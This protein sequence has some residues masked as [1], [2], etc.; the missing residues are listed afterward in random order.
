M[1]NLREYMR[2]K[3]AERR[4][5]CKL[6]GLCADCATDKARPNRTRCETCAAIN[7]RRPHY[8]RLNANSR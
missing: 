8:S 1:T 4:A 6:L 2:A 3:N 5:R 7:N